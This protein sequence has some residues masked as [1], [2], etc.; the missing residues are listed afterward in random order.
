MFELFFN[1]ELSLNNIMGVIKMNYS[2]IKIKVENQY[3]VSKGQLC[4]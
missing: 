4:K 2:Q 1:E 3:K